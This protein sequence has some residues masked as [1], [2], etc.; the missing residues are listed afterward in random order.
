MGVKPEPG[1]LFLPCKRGVERRVYY[2]EFWSQTVGDASFVPRLLRYFLQL[3]TVG[4]S[5]AEVEALDSL[6]RSDRFG[7]SLA[8]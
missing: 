1:A 5:M 6:V 3:S 7:I 4:M 8:I 2:A